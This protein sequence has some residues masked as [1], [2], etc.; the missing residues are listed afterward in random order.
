MFVVLWAQEA[1]TLANDDRGRQ[2]I[3]RLTMGLF[4]VFQIACAVSP[5][6]AA[7]IV[8]RFFAGFFGSPTV[9]NSGGSITDI[10]PQSHRS[11]PMAFFSAGSFLGPVTAPIMGGFISQ[12]TSWRWNFWV[13][14][15]IS[16]VVY[17]A[18]IF[19]LP[20]TYSAYLLHQKARKL[21]RASEV[22]PNHS[23][24]EQLRNSLIRPWLMLCTEPILF[25]LS[26]SMALIYG[27]LYLDFTA[28]PIV[29]K[30][31][32]NW[33]AGIAGL[34]FLGIGV[35]MALATIASPYINVIHA[36]F[37]ARLGGP[38]PE[39]RLPHLIPLAWLIPASLFWFGWSAEPPTHWICGII[40]GAPFGFT[41]IV[42]FLGIMAY[43]TDCYGPFGASALAA[44]NVLRSIFGAVFPLF[45]PDM[46]GG[47][48]VAWATSVLAF[49][50]LALTPLPWVFYR[51][52]PRIRGR[53]RYHQKI[54]DIVE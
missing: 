40:A 21:G 1:R 52:G 19:L 2:P 4:C 5:N 25:L 24:K 43:L 23:P 22:A 47:L 39:A 30:Q 14:L 54:K 34:S 11:V 41:L 33:S 13:V 31:S 28:Y 26:L 16:G 35:G 8:F 32:R 17:A 7:L 45:A 48:G 6:I 29:Y 50:A 15:I 49:V 27:I 10:W 42:L 51:F 38:Q 44:N 36:R 20:E 46:Y 3:Y 9:T 18:V 12:Y 53:S 37:V